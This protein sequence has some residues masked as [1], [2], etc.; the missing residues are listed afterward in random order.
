[1]VRG[2]DTITVAIHV[3]PRHLG[4]YHDNSAGNLQ[5]K[6]TNLHQGILNDMALCQIPWHSEAQVLHLVIQELCV[7][8]AMEMCRTGH[9]SRTMAFLELDI[10]NNVENVCDMSHVLLFT[11]RLR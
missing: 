4:I 9:T 11:T 2:K 8:T 3:H 10:S 6:A 5:D 1:M 7:N